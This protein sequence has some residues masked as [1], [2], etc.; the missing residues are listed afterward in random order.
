M[1]STWESLLTIL[2]DFL[3]DFLEHLQAPVTISSQETL[4]SRDAERYLISQGVDESVP[5]VWIESELAGNTGEIFHAMCETPKMIGD[6]TSE[7]DENKVEVEYD[8]IWLKV[9]DNP[10]TDIGDNERVIT[11]TVIGKGPRWVRTDTVVGEAVNFLESPEA[12][13]EYEW[14]FDENALV[15]ET[16]GFVPVSATA[17]I[18]FDSPH[19]FMSKLQSQVRMTRKA[20]PIEVGRDFSNIEQ[21]NEMERIARYRRNR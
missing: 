13:P 10:F 19:S 20:L 2:D 14:E 11:V 5:A 7:Y 4:K 3:N 18:N 6:D 17:A 15:F 8:A 16:I 12:T 21:D 1:S 9:G